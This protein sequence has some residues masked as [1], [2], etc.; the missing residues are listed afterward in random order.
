MYPLHEVQNCQNSSLATQV[1]RVVIL[2]QASLMSD[3]KESLRSLIP[4]DI[5]RVWSNSI[6]LSVDV[7]KNSS[8]YLLHI[9]TLLC[10]DDAKYNNTK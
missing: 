7:C 2:G 4:Y 9:C 8:S 1:R 3:C 6:I 5:Y 10:G